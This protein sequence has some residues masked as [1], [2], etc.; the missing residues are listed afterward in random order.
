MKGGAAKSHFLSVGYFLDVIAKTLLIL[1]VFWVLALGWIIL[2][3][4]PQIKILNQ[5]RSEHSEFLKAFGNCLH[6]SE[7]FD[8][9]T[10]KE[11][12]GNV[13]RIVQANAVGPESPDSD[14]GRMSFLQAEEKKYLDTAMSGL[15]V[16]NKDTV[17]YGRYWANQARLLRL[18]GLDL[19]D[20]QKA[21][22][23][24]NTLT[25]ARDNYSEAET[26]AEARVHHLS[27]QSGDLK[28]ALDS[29]YVKTRPLRYAAYWATLHDAKQI[30]SEWQFAPGMVECFILLLLGT[31]L[32]WWIHQTGNVH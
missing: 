14:A 22:D 1:G 6:I 15:Y 4:F 32:L 16:N 24:L 3:A 26:L 28:V 8:A 13:I 30:D 17:A 7:R 9:L 12:T 18:L 11:A 31:V 27:S 23:I 2:T 25:I 21:K 29:W 19:K 20:E 10:V 5:V